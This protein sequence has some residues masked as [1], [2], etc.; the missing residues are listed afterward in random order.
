ML[1]T[2]RVKPSLTARL[3]GIRLLS[4]R[5]IALFASGYR[6]RARQGD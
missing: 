1:S 4:K 5:F 2:K 3:L 6:V